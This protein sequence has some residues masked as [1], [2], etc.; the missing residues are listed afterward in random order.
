[1]QGDKLKQ[2]ARLSI[3][4]RMRQK[5]M[6]MSPVPSQVT[7]EEMAEAGE[8]ETL[9]DMNITPSLQAKLRKKKR[10]GP[11]QSPEEAVEPTNVIGGY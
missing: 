6:P 10:I 5:G 4:E 7:P 11:E 1:M 2:Q 8:E 9:N 3:I